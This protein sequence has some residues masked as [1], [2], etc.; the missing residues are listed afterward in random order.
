MTKT[1]GS[2]P[3]V[4]LDLNDAKRRYHFTFTREDHER[5]PFY[6]ALMTAL[7][8][9]HTSLRLLASVRMEQRNPMLIL[10][11]LHL[12]ALTGH[13]IL[14]PIYLDARHGRLGDPVGAA[15]TVIAVLND[16]PELVANELH[17]STQTNEPGRSAIFQAL[18][19][20]IARDRAE[21]I[22]VVDV[23]TS[24]GINL[25][26][27]QFPVKRVDDDNPLTLVCRDETLV[28]RSIP[29]PRV[30]ARVGIDPSPL[31]LDNEGDR[32]WLQACLWPEE[33]RRLDRLE[34]VIQHRTSWPTTTILTGTAR[35]RLSDALDQGDANALTIVMNSYVVGYFSEV[36]QTSYFETMTQHCASSN[37]AWLSLESPFMVQWPTSSRSSELARMGATQVLV[38]LP[39]GEPREWGWCHHHGHW[40]NLSIPA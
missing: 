18:I 24:A 14:G 22:N 2:L 3:S 40:L 16:E 36:D 10:A 8:E 13:P 7:E 32:R 39:G 29:L 11:A 21:V 4:D 34:A 27:D 5:L 37:V 6:S 23:G 31:D 19:A 9:D 1:V 28:D 15:S 35:D 20:H 33:P 30:S 38:T 17:R 25:Y 26:F 12:C